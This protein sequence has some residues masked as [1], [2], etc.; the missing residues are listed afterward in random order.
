MIYIEEERISPDYKTFQDLF[1]DL[2]EI[3]MQPL[4]HIQCL[5]TQVVD[6]SNS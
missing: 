6:V 3:Y 2:R 4:H 1:V 5:Q